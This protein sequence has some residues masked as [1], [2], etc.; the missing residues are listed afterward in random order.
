MTKE[1]ILFIRERESVQSNW[2]NYGMGVVATIA[3]KE[4]NV[5]LID[6]VSKYVT[7]ST[8]DI[9]G[10]I[11]TFKPAVVCFSIATVNA[12]SSYATISAIK[13]LY[14]RLPIVAGSLHVGH[15][16]KEGLDHKI[17][18]IVRGEADLVIIPLLNKIIKNNFD[19]SDSI[20]IEG[21]AYYRNNELVN[22]GITPLPFNLDETSSVDY[23]LYDLDKY[24]RCDADLDLFGRVLTQRGCPFRCT[25][26]SDE[27]TQTKV[28]YRSLD[29]VMIEIEDKY[30]MG[31]KTINLQDADFTM[32]EKRVTDFCNRMIDSGLSKKLKITCQTDSF[33]PF[34]LAT[35]ELMKKAGFTTI[36]LGIE[37]MVKS[38]QV[39]INKKLNNDIVIQNLK[40]IRQVGFNTMVNFLVGFPFETMATLEEETV[41]FKEIMSKYADITQVPIL[42]PMP[43]TVEYDR[44]TSNR[45]WYLNPML[46]QDKVPL[47]KVI[48]RL[49][50]DPEEVNIYGFKKG[51]I[52]KML[53]IREDFRLAG[54]LK[55]SRI[56]YMLYKYSL[57]LAKISRMLYKLNP[58]LEYF[59]FGYLRLVLVNLQDWLTIYWYKK[60]NK[61]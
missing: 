37:R 40:N 59:L 23:K 57:I 54:I 17:D 55:K 52:K 3:S 13:E 36:A 14:P 30:K 29:N 11:K 50:V 43:G 4:F 56:L 2:V 7:Y 15:K 48:E 10:V 8:G 20:D 45:E 34:N 28:R 9:L 41:I 26:C 35:L 31:I 12:Y 47:Y 22:S 53:K 42:M 46:F 51:L 44:L 6:N 21:V 19:K 25:F 24:I 27:F 38:S 39:M 18:Y 60:V 16:Y 33:K 58:K 61:H 32:S 1:N 5:K 49:S